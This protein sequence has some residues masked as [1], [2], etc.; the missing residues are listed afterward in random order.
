ML[1]NKKDKQAGICSKLQSGLEKTRSFLL[2]DLTDLFNN[3]EWRN[4]ELLEEIDGSAVFEIIGFN[5][6]A[7]VEASILMQ[8]RRSFL[9]RKADPGA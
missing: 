6:R 3:R 4:E 7:A 2:S 8:I 5:R 1:I 9:N